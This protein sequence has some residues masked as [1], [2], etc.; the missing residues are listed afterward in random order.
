MPKANNQPEQQPTGWRRWRRQDLCRQSKQVV[1]SG[2][3]TG[4]AGTLSSILFSEL[5]LNPWADKFVSFPAPSPTHNL[6]QFTCQRPVVPDKN[7]ISHFNSLTMLHCGTKLT[8][9]QLSANRC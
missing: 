1:S 6:S 5:A 8:I 7:K 9:W 2:R 3:P 4:D